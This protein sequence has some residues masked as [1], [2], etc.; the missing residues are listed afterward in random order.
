MIHHTRKS[1]FQLEKINRRFLLAIV[2]H[3]LPE[4]G[5]LARDRVRWVNQLWSVRSDL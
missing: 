5:F 4:G 3:H 2:P 1:I